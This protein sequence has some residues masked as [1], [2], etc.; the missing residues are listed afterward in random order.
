MRSGN[1]VA[2][3][4]ENGADEV[5]LSVVSADFVAAVR[6]LTGDRG[7]NVVF[8][9]SGMMFAEAV[10]AAAMAGR[11]PVITAPKD[12]M[13]KFNLRSI[14]RKMMR[15][16]GVDSRDLDAV[17]CAKM[18][19]AMSPSFQSG[20]LRAKAGVTRPLSQAAEAYELAAHDGT[21]VV[22]HPWE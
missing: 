18:L 22:L 21:R 7:A 20:Q 3:A 17:A 11:I 1:D 14:Y 13:A 5:V 12:G 10:E 15:V 9:T 2:A 6:K 16:I 8:D 19:E 4:R